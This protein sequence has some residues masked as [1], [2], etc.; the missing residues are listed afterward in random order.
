MKGYGQFCPIAKA[1]EILTE[2]WTPLVL[3]ELIAGSRRFND[4]RRGVPLM[5]PALLSKRLKQLEG[6][7]LVQRRTVAGGGCEYVPTAA[8]QEL[9]PI[10]RMLGVWGQRWVRSRFGSEDLDPGLL[11]WDIRRKVDPTRFPEGRTV[12]AFELTDAPRNKRHWWLVSE[13]REVDLCVSDPGFEVDLH[14][15][16]DVRTLTRLW[17]GELTLARAVDS[18]ALELV[19]PA[20]LRRRFRSWLGSSAFADVKPARGAT[21]R[22]SR[23][24]HPQ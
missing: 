21:S 13:A 4:L 17:L 24:P 6:A 8:A 1:S 16:T 11:M 14:V 5:S 22:S 12:V 18:G 19:G 7:G 23:S 3:R 9:Q 15:V 20:A 2:R 10:I